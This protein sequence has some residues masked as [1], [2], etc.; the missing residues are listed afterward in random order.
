MQRRGFDFMAGKTHPA[1]W[2]LVA[3]LSAA[4]VAYVILLLVSN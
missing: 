1:W 3:L 4:V 2:G